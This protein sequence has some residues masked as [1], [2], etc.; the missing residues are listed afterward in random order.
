MSSKQKHF[1]NT[2]SSIQGG[3]QFPENRF[4]KQKIMKFDFPYM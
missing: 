1:Q 4:F 2:E 3:H